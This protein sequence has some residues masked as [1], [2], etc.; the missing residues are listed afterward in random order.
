MKRYILATLVVLLPVVVQAQIG[1]GVRKPN[2]SSENIDLNYANPKEYEIAEIKVSGVETLN[3]DALISVAGLRV[4]DRITIP[5]DALSSAINKLWKQG[6]IGDAS[7]SISKVEG[8]KVYLNIDLKERPR[9]TSINIS[10][11]NK[12][13]QK[14]LQDKIKVIRGRVVTDALIKNTEMTIRD[15]Y[16]DKGFLNAEVRVVPEKDT[17]QTNSVKLN[18]LVDKNPKIKIDQINFIGNENI[19]DSR[20][21]SKM[22]STKEKP[23]ITLFEDLI[24]RAI[25]FRPSDL[26]EFFSNKKETE[27]QDIKD[28]LATHVKANIFSGSK[29]IREDFEADKEAVIDFYNS[30]G[31]RD[32][33]IVSDTILNSPKK[34][35]ISLNLR[36]DEGDRYY[37]RD[38]SWE[39]NYVHSDS[40][41][42]R[43]LGVEKGDIYDMALID[44]KLHYNPM[45]SDVSAL[46]MDNGYLFFNANPVEVA[47]EGD[48]IDL[49]IRLTE[50]PQATIKR[51][52]INGNDRTKDHV[53]LR[54]V[55][56]LPGE[57]FSREK[58][59]RTQREILA[60]G[61]FDQENFGM[62][63]IP[64]PQDGTVDIEYTVVEK[65]TDQIELSAG[66]GGRS[67]YG[68]GGFIGT[69]GLVFNNFSIQ[70]IL[71]PRSWD[72]LPVGDGQTLALRVQAS[73]RRYQT[74]SF[75]FVEPWLGGRRPNAFSVN[76]SHSINRSYPYGR[77]LLDFNEEVGRISVTS[78]TVGLGRRI[79]WPDDF[80]TLQNSVSYLYYDIFAKLDEN[81]RPSPYAYAPFESFGLYNGNAN[82]VTLNTTIARN[83]I[84]YPMYPRGGSSLSLQASFTPPYSLFNEKNYE[85]LSTEERFQWVEYHKYMFDADFFTQIIGDLVLN[86][87][88]NMGF[89]GSYGSGNPIGPFERF[90]LG[91]DGMSGQAGGYYIGRDIIGLRGYET[92]SIGPRVGNRTTGTG[93]VVYNKFT[94]QLRYPLSLNPAATIYLQ[95]FGEAGNN[96]GSYREFNPFDLYRSAG[97]GARIF[98][99]AFGLIGID[100]AYGFD[101]IPGLPEQN[102]SQFHFTIGQQIR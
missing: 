55:R 47:V 57:K 31:Y 1:V 41:L 88:A 2:R 14:T 35:M 98:M 62:Q 71:K 27:P 10:G 28:Y 23:R 52:I 72:P 90:V 96:W 9:L 22:R 21:K 46:Y 17:T 81:G 53:I 99:P 66:W 77:A 54:E 15:H 5:G 94:L 33:K 64:N 87:K 69:L 16:V 12:S 37:F 101:E 51:V 84:N 25:N 85:E 6:I 50:G 34:N 63:P 89:I 70:N 56:T 36:V 49:E 30:Q 82:T 24:R 73:G 3:T 42:N 76:L 58:L 67:S 20:L 26:V 8:D 78:A 29:F 48:S 61:F 7:I 44:K 18:I 45:G 19:A 59:I 68:A 97:I 4:G 32:A 75:S 60:L 39:G 80:F 86:A 74:Y 92:T 38:I 40:L 65:P 102:G 93:G 13:Q 11:V 43:I 79:R 95:A 100:W 83:S 91:G